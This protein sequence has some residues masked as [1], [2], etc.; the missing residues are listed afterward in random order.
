[1]LTL[2]HRDVIAKPEVITVVAKEH[3]KRWL[4]YIVK[5]KPA[6]SEN[7]NTLKQV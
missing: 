5:L 6:E 7:N 3:A 2:G 4:G 1:M